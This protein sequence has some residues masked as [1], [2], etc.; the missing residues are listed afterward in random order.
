MGR[1]PAARNVCAFGLEY[2]DLRAGETAKNVRSQADEIEG[3]FLY[4]SKPMFRPEMTAWKRTAGA[5][6]S[7]L[8]QISKRSY[9]T[10]R[11]C[12]CTFLQEYRLGFV[13]VEADSAEGWGRGDRE[14]GTGNRERLR[15]QLRRLARFTALLKSNLRIADHTGAPT[16]MED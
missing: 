6:M 7:V 9:G 15:Q 14:Q 8:K 1:R 4:V 3:F 16:P 10:K 5:E 2:V 11:A 12:F 13:G